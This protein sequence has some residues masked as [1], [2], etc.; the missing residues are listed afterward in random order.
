MKGLWLSGRVV[1]FRKGMIDSVG[2]EMED[3]TMRSKRKSSRTPASNSKGFSSTCVRG[4]L[5]SCDFDNLSRSLK[6]FRLEELHV[7]SIV[8][9]TDDQDL[10]G[11]VYIDN[12]QQ[13]CPG[14]VFRCWASIV[15]F[16]SRSPRNPRARRVHLGRYR[17]II[18]AASERCWAM[19]SDQNTMYET[20]KFL[21][22][23]LFVAPN[24]SKQ[25]SIIMVFS[26]T[27][28]IL[29]IFALE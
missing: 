17:Y 26:E 25:V 19:L 7:V 4:C 9:T 16:Y 20:K 23:L 18:W 8:Q 27:G 24:Q 21:R 11:S 29:P 5:I 13:F 15:N 22:L 2:L 1:G 10:R 12:W 6:I 3:G 28:I 14:N